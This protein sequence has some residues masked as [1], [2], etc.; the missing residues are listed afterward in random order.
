MNEPK[1][2][3]VITVSRFFKGMGADHEQAEVMARQLLKRAVQLSAER[4]LTIVE[5]TGILLKQVTEARAGRAPLINSEVK[6]KA[7]SET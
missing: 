5:S 7:D 4:G 1:E 2:E 3:E 6:R